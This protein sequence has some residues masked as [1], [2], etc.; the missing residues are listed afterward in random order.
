MACDVL[1]LD[2]LYQAQLGDGSVSHRS[3]HPDKDVLVTSEVSNYVHVFI[4]SH[5]ILAN[6]LLPKSHIK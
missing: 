4:L 2:G 3:H 6:G 1:V 5:I